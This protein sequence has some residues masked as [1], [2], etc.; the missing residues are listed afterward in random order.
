[1]LGLARLLA[2]R[3]WRWADVLLCGGAIGLALAVRVG[4]VL[5]LVL[6]I[7]GLALGACLDREQRLAWR[8]HGRQ[9]ALQLL[10]LAAVAWGVMVAGW[11]WAHGAPLTR[12]LLA[13]HLMSDFGH[14]YPT[15][16]EGRFQGSA[17]LPRYYVPKYLAITTPLSLL[18]LA[19][20]GGAAGLVV[21]LR[22]RRVEAGTPVLLAWL[23]LLVPVAYAV[24]RRP[25]VYDGIRHFLFVLPALALLAARGVETLLARAGRRRSLAGVVLALALAFPLVDLVTLHPYQSSYFNALTGGTRGAWGRY[26]MDYWLGSYREAAR[27]IIEDAWTRPGQETV[28]VVACNDNNRPCIS[29]YLE[30]RIATWKPSDVPDAAPR[31]RISM[32]CVWKRDD[33]LPRDADYYVATLRYGKASAFLA[34]WPVVH[35][36]ERSGAT[37]SLIRRNPRGAPTTD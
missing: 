23:W 35:R 6:L 29:H 31:P 1:M 28:I 25:N 14:S 20:I 30:T 34:D 4:A 19:A 7:L 13:L 32:S 24:V 3:E 12:P 10:A 5:L 33:P 16:F 8:A 37:F 2:A 27:W 11:P 22:R 17:D 26:E 21:T 9:R 36:I 18:A 15:L